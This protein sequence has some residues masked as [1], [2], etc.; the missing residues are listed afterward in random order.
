M[1]SLRARIGAALSACRCRSSFRLLWLSP[2]WHCMEHYPESIET[3]VSYVVRP[4]RTPGFIFVVLAFGWCAIGIAIA[5]VPAMYYVRFY[6]AFLV[7]GRVWIRSFGC[8]VGSYRVEPTI[9]RV[10]LPST[11]PP[12]PRSALNYSG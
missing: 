11:V 9:T 3:M 7:V 12:R 2:C 4:L 6:F 1:A 5:Y 10:E 8:H